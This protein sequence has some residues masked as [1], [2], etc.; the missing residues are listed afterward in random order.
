[1]IRLL[2]PTRCAITSFT[3]LS[4]FP[5]PVIPWKPS[6]SIDKPVINLEISLAGLFRLQIKMFRN[7]IIDYGKKRLT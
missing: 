1:M 6:S 2:F 5:G 7:K 4:F 3:R